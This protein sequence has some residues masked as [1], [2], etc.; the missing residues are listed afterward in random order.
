MK[1]IT[2]FDLDGVLV[3]NVSYENAVTELIVN[4]IGSNRKIPFQEAMSVWNQT[5]AANSKDPRWHDYGL[6][7]TVLGVPDAWQSSHL[8]MRHLLRRMPNAAESIAV[9]RETGDCWLASDATQWVAMFKLG[10]AGIDPRVFSEIF[11]LDRCG[12][13]KGHDAYWKCLV[14]NIKNTG[15]VP[16]Y[17]DNRLDRLLTAA[18]FLPN[19]VVVHV[20]AEDHPTSLRL[21]P[22]P[23]K[24]CGVRLHN[25]THEQLPAVLRRIACDLSSN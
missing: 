11:T 7:C 6:H 18:Q 15:A 8:A 2:I 16:I 24:A 13:S 23:E 25:V 5:L 19:V 12:V 10:V 14:S 3:D 1:L 22:E 21:F 20:A 17:V 9:A 4:A